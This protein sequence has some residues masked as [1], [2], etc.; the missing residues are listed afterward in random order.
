MI[1]HFLPVLIYLHLYAVICPLVLHLTHTYM[2]VK[3]W[4]QKSQDCYFW[5]SYTLYHAAIQKLILNYFQ[6]CAQFIIYVNTYLCIYLLTY[7]F[8]CLIMVTSE[9]EYGSTFF[10]IF[11]WT[12]NNVLLIKDKSK[13]WKQDGICF[14]FLPF[15]S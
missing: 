8:H 7:T 13:K 4:V 10:K 15:L 11:H 12:H 2:C 3:L 14:A 6:I 9:R 5:I 1:W